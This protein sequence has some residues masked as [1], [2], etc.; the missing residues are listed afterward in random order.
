MVALDRFVQPSSSSLSWISPYCCV[1]FEKPDKVCTTELVLPSFLLSTM[2]TVYEP[3]LLF[4]L[5]DAFV[6]VKL[7]DYNV[8]TDIEDGALTEV[9]YAYREG[10]GIGQHPNTNRG[11][12]S[13]NM[14]TGASV[15]VSVFGW[16]IKYMRVYRSKW[17]FHSDNQFFTLR[18][19]DAVSE[20]RNASAISRQAQWSLYLRHYDSMPVL[21]ILSVLDWL[22]EHQRKWE[23]CCLFFRSGLGRP[24]P[25]GSAIDTDE[26]V[27]LFNQVDLSLRTTNHQGCRAENPILGHG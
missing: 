22:F 7:Q 5:I 9:I 4:F 14:A 20:I 27:E 26:G 15:S 18:T 24:T 13:V 17:I 11:A 12:A 6:L 16:T 21:C 23:F 19:S 25:K 10:A 2:S 8:L 3:W 1:S